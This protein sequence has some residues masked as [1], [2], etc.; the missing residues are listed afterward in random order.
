[1]LDLLS[2]WHFETLCFAVTGCVYKHFNTAC[3]FERKKESRRTERE[4]GREEG[5]REGGGGGKLGGRERGG[6]LA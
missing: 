5:E 6:T 1:M 3:L 2:F 4:T